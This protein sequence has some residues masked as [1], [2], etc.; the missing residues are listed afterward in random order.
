MSEENPYLAPPD[1]ASA[2]CYWTSRRLH[3]AAGGWMFFLGLM[4]LFAT[5][6]LVVDAFHSDAVVW[7]I[8]MG[9][10][11]GMVTLQWRIAIT[12]ARLAGSLILAGIVVGSALLIS[13]ILS[14]GESVA[15]GAEQGPQQNG[16]LIMFVAIAVAIAPP[17]WMLQA[18]LVAEKREDQAA[19]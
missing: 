17:W 19:N 4:V 5:N 14:T 10:L 6:L 1:V 7:P 12:I 16:M 13:G 3:L 11:G 15:G 8:V 18:A 9:V 2:P